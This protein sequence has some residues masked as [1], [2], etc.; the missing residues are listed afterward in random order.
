MV[1]SILEYANCIW[2]PIFKRQSVIIENVQRRAT[3]MLPDLF[4]MSY[5]DRLRYLKIPSLKYRRIRGDL[6]QL[7]KIV[8]NIDNVDASKFFKF[9]HNTSTRGDK[10]KIFLERYN[11][12]IRKNYFISRTIN[13]WNSLSFKSKNSGCLNGFKNAIDRELVHLRYVYD[14]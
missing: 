13:L 14:H 10:F 11:T 8:H 7:F 9:S 2:S 1:R 6:I 12:N 5:D 4:H 3:R